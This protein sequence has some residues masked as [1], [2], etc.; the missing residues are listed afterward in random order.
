MKGTGHP[1]CCPV[2]QKIPSSGT[3]L[4]HLQMQVETSE[5][6]SAVQASKTNDNK[7]SLL[8]P[9]PISILGHDKK[10]SCFATCKELDK[11]VNLY[12]FQC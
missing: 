10:Y 7:L 6:L 1:P 4:G 3:A 8:N 5:K 11:I 2:P 9:L 12:V